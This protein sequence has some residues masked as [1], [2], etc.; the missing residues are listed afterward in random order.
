M[1][2]LKDLIK[3]DDKWFVTS[4]IG[5]LYSTGDFTKWEVYKTNV[6]NQEITQTK[7]TDGFWHN[8]SKASNWDSYFEFYGFDSKNNYKYNNQFR[9]FINAYKDNGSDKGS[10]FRTNNNTLITSNMFDY[11]VSSDNG[12]TWDSVPENNK[13]HYYKTKKFKQFDNETIYCFVNGDFLASRDEGRSWDYEQGNINYNF[14]DICPSKGGDTLYAT[15]NGIKKGDST[16]IVVPFLD[17]ENRIDNI[18]YVI[19]KDL[20]FTHYL[21]SISGKYK[22]HRY[23]NYGENEKITEINLEQIL[24]IDTL[25]NEEIISY[26]S[27]NWGN[28]YLL[29]PYNIYIL[30]HNSDEL[31]IIKPIEGERFTYIDFDYID[32]N[33][34]E[35][36]I[37][38]TTNTGIFKLSNPT[39][40]ESEI[41]NNIFIITPNPVTDRFRLELSSEMANSK[42]I[43]VKLIDALGKVILDKIANIENIDISSLST[44]NYFIQIK[45]Y[46]KNIKTEMLKLV[47]E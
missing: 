38:Y 35:K 2:Y 8:I 17:L 33:Q 6:S 37:Y 23:Y 40:L 1:S 28:I 24:Y 12:S 22:I 19:N 16:G 4:P 14:L 31:E 10:I 41:Q 13:K 32:D 11:F 7:Y 27:D 45:Y 46:D 34:T 18:Q 44:G 29:S 3:I 30:N 42:I 36:Q 21:D 47:K 25:I 9:H 15:T 5:L 26:R 39:S 20:V 43:E